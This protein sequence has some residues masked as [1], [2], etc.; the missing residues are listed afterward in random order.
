[1]R[2]VLHG[3]L[4]KRRTADHGETT[5]LLQSTGGEGSRP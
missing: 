4:R 2:R 1:L 5:V 3:L